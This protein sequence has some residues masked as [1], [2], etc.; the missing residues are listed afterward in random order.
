MSKCILSTICARV[1][2][3]D[4]N[5][6]NVVVLAQ[7]FEGFYKGGAVVCD[8]FTKSAPLAKNIIEY[9][10]TNGLCSLSVKCYNFL[11]TLYY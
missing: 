2:P 9:P 11:P 1:I 8:N 5:V 4:S 7:I 3:Q 6:A 10:I